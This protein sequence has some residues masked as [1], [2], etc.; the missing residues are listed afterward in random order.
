MRLGLSGYNSATG[1][2]YQNRDIAQRL[3][4]EKWLVLKHPTKPELPAIP[5]LKTVVVGF[6][7]SAAFLKNWLEGIDCL[8]FYEQPFIQNLPQLARS[9][10][11]AVA[12]IPNWEWISPTDRW[13]EQV[14]LFICPNRHTYDLFQHWKTASKQQWIVSHVPAPVEVDRFKF[15]PKSRCESFLFINGNGGCSPYLRGLIRDRVG[16]KRKGIDTI[17]QAA[18][19]APDV[20]IYLRSQTDDL[21]V[22]PKNIAVLPPLEDNAQI[23]AIGDV[24]LQPSLF[25]G[26]GLQL[27]ETLSTGM[28][29]VTTNASPMNELPNIG[30][31]SCKS[32]PGKIGSHL[33]DIHLPDAS[34][35]A[36]IMKGLFQQDISLHSQM[37]R[38][39]VEE[40]HTW[41]K[42]LANIQQDLPIKPSGPLPAEA[43]G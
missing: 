25:E 4:I 31:I 27:L 8:I 5:S 22:L 34:H 12:C 32:L 39:H 37:A 18:R 33:I 29:L 26:T 11:V 30:L 43:A 42:A 2:G 40:N 14:D 28:P 38:R 15:S 20:P 9:A 13:I 7:A 10:G 1:L 6:D 17:V 19:M 16:P 24:A 21:P 41:E 36:A 3:P 35:L 23:Y